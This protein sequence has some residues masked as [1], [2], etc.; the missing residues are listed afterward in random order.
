[1]ATC[2]GPPDVILMGSPTVL[3][4][5]LMAARIG[6]PTVHGGVIVLGCFTVIIGE[7]G[8]P[9]PSAPSAPA[10]PGAAGLASAAILPGAPA[11]GAPPP[12]AVR[13]TITKPEAEALF[14]EL[15]KQPQIPFDYPVDCCY[16]RAHEMGR[17][18]ESKSIKSQKYWLFDKNWGS[19]ESQA[20]LAPKDKSGD[21]VKFPDSSGERK[22]V[23]WVYHV[24]PIVKVKQ[25]DG[26]V[27]D[28]VM[29]P[30]I[31]SEPVTTAKWRSIQGNPD[32]AY[33]QVTDS[34]AFF[35]NSKNGIRQED[36]D[37][38]KTKERLKE[39]VESRDAALEREKE[40]SKAK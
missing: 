39:H 10:V 20:S 29:D 31:A 37:G 2:V 6:D 5:N 1:M 12:P 19:P 7:V 38:S 13:D 9:S 32:G 21:P 8:T 25:E 35:A 33:D 11:G 28:M 26:S 16:A 27:T 34:G 4:G 3:I 36:A 17:I 15:A 40:K 24:A 18:M 23:K 30:S 22:P 14:K